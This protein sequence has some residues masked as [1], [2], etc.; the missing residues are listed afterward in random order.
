MEIL[1]LI[2]V[3]ILIPIVT[4][5]LGFFGGKMYQI[6]IIKKHNQNKNISLSGDNNINGKNNELVNQDKIEDSNIE[7]KVSGEK[8]LTIITNGKNSQAAGRDI[9]NGEQQYKYKR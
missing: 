4:L 1:R 5:V 3:D 9:I 7:Y 8:N 6:K 2:F